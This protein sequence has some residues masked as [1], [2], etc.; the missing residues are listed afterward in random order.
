MIL[1]DADH[2]FFEIWDFFDSLYDL[3]DTIFF[4]ERDFHANARGLIQIHKKLINGFIL[5]SDQSGGY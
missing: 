4:S 2:S 1:V 5:P 3:V